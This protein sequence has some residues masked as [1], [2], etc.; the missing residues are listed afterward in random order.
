MSEKL[1]RLTAS[2]VIKALERV[3]FLFSRQSGSH[4]I[5]RSSDGRRATVPFHAGKILHPK[6]LKSI[7]KEANLSVEELSD[8][9]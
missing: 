3:G 6:I 5:F 1:P 8:L 2:Q 4:M 7:M 9:L